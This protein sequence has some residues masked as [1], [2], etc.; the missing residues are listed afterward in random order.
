MFSIDFTRLPKTNFCLSYYNG[1]E[2]E[3][4]KFKV[5]SSKLW[6]PFCLRKVT[7][8]FSKVEMKDISLHSAYC[9]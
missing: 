5:L 4:C 9:I 3:I 8:D 6:Y 7:K 2:T 1:I